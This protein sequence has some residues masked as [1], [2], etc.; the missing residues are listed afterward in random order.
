MYQASQAAARRVEPVRLP[1]SSFIMSNLPAARPV[2]PSTATK[3]GKAAVQKRKV[4]DT[5]KTKKTKKANDGK[6]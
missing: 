2:P 4:Q 5:N 6:A 1:D 3:T